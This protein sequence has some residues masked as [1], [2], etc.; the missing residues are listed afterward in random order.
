[1]N[2]IR[3]RR[4]RFATFVL[5]ALLNL[6]ACQTARINHFKGFAQAGIAYARATEIVLE[7]AGAT[8]IDTDSMVIEGTRREL[9]KD[10]Q[11][12]ELAKELEELI[13]EHNDELKKRLVLLGDLMRHARLLRSYFEALGALAESDAPSGIGEAAEGVVNSLGKLHGSIEKATVGDFAVSEFVGSV[14]KIA[15]ANFKLAALER[16]LKANAGTIERELDL[17]QAALTAVTEQLRTD[18]EAQLLRQET[19]E[20]V[21]PFLEES[22]LPGSWTRRRREVLGANLSL[23]SVSAAADAAKKLKMSFLSLVEGRFTASDLPA[24]I[25]DINKIV[26]LVENVR[27]GGSGEP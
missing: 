15:V 25:N 24:L 5:L 1:M 17:Q 8:A 13:L 21:N 19:T 18:L 10:K 6:S 12:E 27:G 9:L 11:G 20:V 16:E 7:E 2:S 26:T 14:A 23:A 4:K 22:S 3:S